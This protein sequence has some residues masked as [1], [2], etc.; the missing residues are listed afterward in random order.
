MWPSWLILFIFWAMISGVEHRLALSFKADPKD[1]W[2]STGVAGSRILLY[3][4]KPTA[5]DATRR[6]SSEE[7]SFLP[8]IAASVLAEF[9]TTMSVDVIYLE[10]YA[11]SSHRSEDGVWNQNLFE[12]VSG[13]NIFVLISFCLSWKD[14]TNSRGFSPKARLFFITDTLAF[15]SRISF[16]VTC[17]ANLSMSCGLSSPSSG[18]IVPIN[19][20]RAGWPREMASRSTIFHPEAATSRMSSVMWSGRRWPHQC[21][22]HSD[23]PLPI[24]QA[25]MLLRRA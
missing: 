18:F 23:L 3:R 17:S 16:T 12:A 5:I 1:S 6:T 25:P 11:C 19:M 4:P 7:T 14:L 24:F 13:S 22:E 15:S 9:T 10:C 8:L 20:K 21:I 2:I